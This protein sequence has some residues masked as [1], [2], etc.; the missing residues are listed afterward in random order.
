MKHILS[1][2]SQCGLPFSII[3]TTPD[4]LGS[5]VVKDPLPFT[6]PSPP[7][8][9]HPSSSQA[10]SEQMMFAQPTSCSSGPLSLQDPQTPTSCYDPT[11]FPS[12]ISMHSHSSPSNEKQSKANSHNA[13]DEE[14]EKTPVDTSVLLAQD[15]LGDELDRT[16]QEGLSSS[17]E[18]VANNE[19]EVTIEDLDAVLQEDSSL[20]ES[21]KVL[22]PSPLLASPVDSDMEEKLPLISSVSLNEEKVSVPLNE[23][24]SSQEE[25][26]EMDSPLPS[27]KLQLSLT[28]TTTTTTTTTTTENNSS[29]NATQ[30]QNREVL[31]GQLVL[32][33]GE[34]DHTKDEENCPADIEKE[35]N[36]TGENKEEPSDPTG[37]EIRSKESASQAEELPAPTFLAQ[38]L[39]PE[40]MAP[41]PET[42][43]TS[44]DSHVTISREPNAK[45]D[46]EMKT[47]LESDFKATPPDPSLLAPSQKE[48][49][50]CGSSDPSQ[51]E[52]K[53]G[54]SLSLSFNS[55]STTH[56][57]SQDSTVLI[58]LCRNREKEGTLPEL[59]EKKQTE[60]D[61]TV[62]SLLEVVNYNVYFEDSEEDSIETH[63]DVTPINTLTNVTPINTLTNETPINTLTNVTP[64]NT[65]TN[66]T[67]IM[68]PLDIQKE[69]VVIEDLTVLSEK[70]ESI[71]S[72][73][74]SIYFLEEPTEKKKTVEKVKEE[75]MKRQEEN[76]LEEETTAVESDEESDLELH[77]LA[78]I[79]ERENSPPSPERGKRVVLSS[80]QED[81][82]IPLP[83]HDVVS[84]APSAKRR[85]VTQLNSGSTS[86]GRSEAR[87]N[88]VE[89]ERTMKALEALG[90]KVGIGS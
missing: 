10:S 16:L 83:R 12:Q 53:L 81:T 2:T 90:I 23:E 41:E 26:V 80:Q 66:V 82:S 73:D 79:E 35:S 74:D 33:D 28:I 67:P 49:L 63:T 15:M 72:E 84:P 71:T 48:G 47:T 62:K 57:Q 38:S 68:A 22:S 86:S 85:N 21:E 54:T 13:N 25:A 61:N 58:P 88:P 45:A 69:S 43:A 31:P 24:M 87:R 77:P 76:E 52:A 65:L 18:E 46:P 8:S 19:N 56:S 51:A 9:Q 37:Q 27:P 1:Q 89:N 32:P 55:S 20:S 60:K 4:S 70:S 7:R 50:A 78:V 6:V 42:K 3:P 17:E 29:G 5:Q 44:S 75:P 34:M 11:P 14:K 59:K 40:A 36:K 39:P 64:I 30:T